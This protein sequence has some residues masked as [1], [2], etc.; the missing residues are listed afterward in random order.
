MKSVEN[1]KY[2]LRFPQ[3]KLFASYAPTSYPGSYLRY[4]PRFGK[5]LGTRLLMRNDVFVSITVLAKHAGSCSHVTQLLYS[6]PRSQ[7]L[8]SPGGLWGES[9]G[10]RW[11]L[12]WR[13]VFEFPLA[14]LNWI[15][16]HT[17]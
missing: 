10:T 6:Q 7:A 15:R 16:K 1:L 11:L 14:P 9:L 8:S 12:Y 5:S 13:L 4:P 3:N 2:F 17:N